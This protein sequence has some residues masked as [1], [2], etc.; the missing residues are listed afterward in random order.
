MI[1]GLLQVALQ[2]AICER[3]GAASNRSNF[4]GEHASAAFNSATIATEC[5]TR[6]WR[7]TQQV[8]AASVSQ[9]LLLEPR[10]SLPLFSCQPGVDTH[11]GFFFH[12][13]LSTPPPYGR[14]SA[15]P[16]WPMTHAPVDSYLSCDG[17][18]AGLKKGCGWNAHR[19]TLKR[20]IFHSQY[21]GGFRKIVGL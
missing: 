21:Q 14:G 16:L 3:S 6:W 4:F 2:T 17:S 1:V 10:R 5:G 7:G 9:A 8:G 12:F 18:L 13:C 11:L 15:G 19:R 20:S